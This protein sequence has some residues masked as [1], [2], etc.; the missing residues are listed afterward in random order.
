MSKHSLKATENPEE[1]IIALPLDEIVRKGARKMLQKALEVEID[2]FIEQYQYILDDEG[3]RLIVRN[4]YARPRKIITGA[5]QLEVR[6]PRLDDR[7]LD[8]HNEPRFRSALI[9][10]Y[11][12]RTKNINE[13]IPLLYL[14]GIST[15]DFTEILQALL[16]KEVIG[17]SPDNIVRLKQIWRKEYEEWN[18]KDLSNTNYVYW[19]IDGV[20][21]NV[22]LDNDRQCILV[23]IGARKDG[24]KE[25]VALE[26][27]FRES[28]ES[29]LSLLRALKRRGL[30]KGPK[31]ATGDG[32]LGFWAALAEEYP[33]TDEQRCWV[34]KTS[35][36]LDKMP[37][38]I[39]GKAKSMI[40]DI[41]LAP[42][43]VDA[44]IAFDAFIET[45]DAKY[46][47]AVECLKK[48]RNELMVFYNYPAEHWKHLRSTNP[49]ESTFA[50]VRLR[51][52]KTKGCGSRIATLTM[53]FKLLLSAQKRWKR[54]RSYRKIKDVLNGVEFKDGIMIPS[55][56]TEG[57][58]R[59]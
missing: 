8:K 37:K 9:P 44:N 40:H 57:V 11:L 50:T 17:L 1:N 31:S 48:D 2:S 26:D 56:K 42:T 54:L 45:F 22:R 33:D 28:K 7:V 13:F 14:K 36:V 41:Y 52:K 27:G 43:K 30:K 39:Q 18:K 16:G 23:V 58:V 4:G 3:K 15:G 35:N 49:I 25:L 51:T 34:H 32:A 46:S 19:W 5:G 10:P 12:R 53:V 38:S 59:V 6:T 55:E 21:F 20:Y 29:W 24:K 47:N